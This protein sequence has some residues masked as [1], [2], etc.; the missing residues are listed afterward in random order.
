MKNNDEW[1]C[2]SRNE[3]E[4]E[5]FLNQFKGSFNNPRVVMSRPVQSFEILDMTYKGQLEDEKVTTITNLLDAFGEL[6]KVGERYNLINEHGGIVEEDGS[7]TKYTISK[8]LAFHIG[9]SYYDCMSGGCPR[10]ELALLRYLCL[11]PEIDKTT[12]VYPEIGQEKWSTIADFIKDTEHIDINIPS[13]LAQIANI[14][15]LIEC[16]KVDN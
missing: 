6:R 10:A 12:P 4:L 13:E 11:Y 14:Q 1:I 2:Y 5:P 3:K 16:K 9:M 7:K 8:A 15:K